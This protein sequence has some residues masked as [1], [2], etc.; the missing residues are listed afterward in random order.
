MEEDLKKAKDYIS[1]QGYGGGTNYTTNLVAV[2]LANY[3]EQETKKLKESVNSWKEQ[4]LSYQKNEGVALLDLTKCENK[5]E[6]LQKQ[7]A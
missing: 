3:L 4:A 6:E 7:T 5:L 2:L 1:N